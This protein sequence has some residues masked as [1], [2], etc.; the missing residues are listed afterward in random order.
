MA[1]DLADIERKLVSV[2]K[3]PA[4]E[5]SAMMPR[6][7]EIDR[8]RNEKHATILAH[9]YQIPPIQLLAD[10]SGDSLAL[11]L[12][13]SNNLGE[14]SG[15]VVSSTVYFM[16]EMVK[17]LSPNK[18]VVIPDTKASCSIAEGMNADTVKKIRSSYPGSAIVA[19]INTTADV[20]AQVD[21]VCTSANAETVIRNITGDPVILIPDY[22]FA[23]NILAKMGREGGRKYLAY[24]GITDGDIVL[25]DVF[26]KKEERI[27]AGAELP[28]LPDGTCMVH[29]KFTPFDIYEYRKRGDIDVALAHPEVRPE[30]AKAADVVGGTGKM[31]DYL[32]KN[33][34]ARRILFITECDM[35]AP[36]REAFPDREFLTSC[37]FCDYMRKNNLD[38][39]LA[40]LRDEVYEV[41]LDP[42]TA[43]GARRSLERMFELTGVA[44]GK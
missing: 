43:K 14:G 41:K 19:Y 26:G 39:L 9:Y 4:P 37:R 16:A 8:I 32:R 5:V 44:Y 33:P 40:S 12:H 29:N 7:L 31:I 36:L 27:G 2:H 30:V 3:Y 1:V 13:A 38:N 10:K 34:Q 21:A 6:L 24:K 28:K 11:A 23:Q 17:L 22:F 18:K 15:L 20:K 35:A 25:E 42:V